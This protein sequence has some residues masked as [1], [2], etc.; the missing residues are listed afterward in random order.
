MN[1]IPGETVWKDLTGALGILPTLFICAVLALVFIYVF[2]LIKNGN[3]Q[4]RSPS[5][6]RENIEN[7]IN[8]LNTVEQIAQQ[9]TNLGTVLSGA[10]LTLASIHTKVD[11]LPTKV[12]HLPTTEK[13]LDETKSI[14]HGMNDGYQKLLGAANS[15]YLDVTQQAENNTKKIL[16]AVDEGVK[17]GVRAV[18]AKIVPVD[19]QRSKRK[20]Q[21][22]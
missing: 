13:L 20:R 18:T 1:Q 4:G 19:S 7:Q 11:H 2:K 17:T 3:G 5:E 9:M 22:K 8:I 12:D 10:S 15:H 21:K 14:R 6:S 16:S